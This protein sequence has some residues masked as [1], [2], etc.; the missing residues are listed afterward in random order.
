MQK[1]F[2]LFQFSWICLEPPPKTTCQAVQVVVQG[3][4][5]LPALFLKKL[6]QIVF[7]WETT[8]DVDIVAIQVGARSV[9]DRLICSEPKL[10][11]NNE[12]L[13]WEDIGAKLPRDGLGH[14]SLS[15]YSSPIVDIQ[16]VIMYVMCIGVGLNL[17]N[18][19]LEIAQG[20]GLKTITTCI[21]N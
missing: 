10:G 21:T 7:R 16:L 18:T 15:P 19:I 4:I 14:H 9:S 20:I 5:S 13:A 12:T 8:L 6:P 3:R 1:V 11:L 2:P 17:T